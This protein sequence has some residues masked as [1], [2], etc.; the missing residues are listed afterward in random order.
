MAATLRRFDNDT[1]KWSSLSWCMQYTCIHFVLS[2]H[3]LGIIITSIIVPHIMYIDHLIHMNIS[4][5]TRMKHLNSIIPISL[6]SYM[7]LVSYAT[8]S[9]LLSRFT[10]F[11]VCK[12]KGWPVV[13]LMAFVV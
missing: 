10:A 6:V 12:R 13:Y 11:E 2:C 9:R 5:E 1:I 3:L 4:W 7:S 8:C